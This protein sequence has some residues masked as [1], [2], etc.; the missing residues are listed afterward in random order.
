MKGV[1]GVISSAIRSADR[2]PKL[3]SAKSERMTSNL[4]ASSAATTTAASSARSSRWRMC[5]GAA[6]G[7]VLA[8]T[9]RPPS[10][11]FSLDR[12][13]FHHLYGRQRD[14]ERRA[15]IH[16]ALGLH[17]AAVPLDDAAHIGEA[18]SRALEFIGAVKPLEHPEELVRVLHVETH[19]IVPHEEHGLVVALLRADLDLGTLPGRGVLDGV[20]D[21]VR[22][23]HPEHGEDALTL[24]QR[25]IPPHY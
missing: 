23:D 19:A 12:V 4:F 15:A 21:Q 2:P 3:G 20:R 6:A 1:S 7:L 8:F 18:D 17:L 24:R 13:M 10:G 9:G 11:C 22:E 14:R 25:C 16:F 5:H